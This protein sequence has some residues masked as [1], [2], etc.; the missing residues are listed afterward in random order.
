MKKK[1]FNKKKE[2]EPSNGHGPAVCPIKSLDPLYYGELVTVS[3][4]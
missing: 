1:I 2:R 4:K 3:V